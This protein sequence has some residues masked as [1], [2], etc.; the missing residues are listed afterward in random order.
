VANLSPAYATQRGE[1][2]AASRNILDILE[3]GV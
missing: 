2:K 1:T 3:G